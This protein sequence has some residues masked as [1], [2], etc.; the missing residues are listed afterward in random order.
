[1]I[2]TANR[3]YLVPLICLA[4]IL[5]IPVDGVTGDSAAQNSTDEINWPYQLSDL[6]PDPSIVR[7]ILPNG[8]RYI[9]KKNSEPEDRVAAY[10][11]VLAGSMEETDDEQGVAHFLEHLMFNGSTNFPPGTLIDYFQSIGMDF[12][13][14]I[15]AYTGFEKT[16]YHLILPNGKGSELDIGCKVLADYARGAL[17]LDTEIDS[18][19]GV[20]FSEKRSRDSASYRNHVASSEFSFKGTRYPLRRP[21]GKESVLKAAD[22]KLLK[23]YYDSW[24]RLDNMILVLVGDLDLDVAIKAITANFGKLQSEGIVKA[25]PEF[26]ALEHTGVDV[27]YRYDPEIGKTNVSIETYWDVS[28]EPPSV[29]DEK[30]EIVK[31][32][33]NLVVGYRLQQVQETAEQPYAGARYSAGIVARR[34]G[35]G[36]ILGVT[37]SKSWVK[38]LRVLHETIESARLYGFTAKEVTRAKKEIHANLET[39]VQTESSLHS[40]VIAERIVNHFVD[41]D[42]YMSP[43][44]ERALYGPMLD[45][46]TIEDINK[47]FNKIWENTSRLISVTGDTSLDEGG[48]AE[49]KHLYDSLSKINYE[50]KNDEKEIV[51]PYLELPAGAAEILTKQVYPALGVSRYVYGNGLI[52]NLKRTDFEENKIRISANFGRG[53]QDEDVQGMAMIA[54]DVI[55]LSGTKRLNVSDLNSVMAGSSVKLS[56]RIGRQSST[57]MGSALSEDIDLFVQLLHTMLLDSKFDEVAFNKVMRRIQLMYKKLDSDIDGAV[58]RKVQPF[59]G[60]NNPHYGLPSLENLNLLNYSD[61]ESWAEEHFEIHDLEINVVG[62]FDEGHIV[63][64]LQKTFGGLK[65]GPSP[66]RILN[67]K[68]IFPE[69][70]ELVARVP[71]EI[72]KSSVILTW[73]TDDFWNIERTRRLSILASVLEDRIR[74]TVREKLGASYSPSVVSYGSRMHSHH[75]YIQ[76]ELNIESGKEKI[77][78]GEIRKIVRQLVDAGVTEDELSRAKKPVITSV[79]ENIKTNQY[80][81]YSVLSLSDSYPE[82]L[83]WPKTIVSDIKSINVRQ[84]DTLA[85]KYLNDQKV[86]VAIIKA[87]PYE[88]IE[89]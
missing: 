26:G 58:L 60:G 19:R 57:W 44:Q 45:E 15:N 77:L 43:M 21:I 36:S 8:L 83:E 62:D 29:K 69:G 82:Q 48:K 11:A 9:L 23:G 6:E 73:P 13:G 33:G 56:Y 3:Y 61:M 16:V 76:V 2:R 5:L 22:H 68:I 30:E 31:I 84:V 7:G 20:I 39:G 49:I 4:M 54:D 53:E 50:P 87:G 67:E 25:K 86:A 32:I 10:L 72:E 17:L 74:K 78:V 63:S 59:L 37:D 24:Y 35:Y 42:V 66:Q 51:F 41:G 28:P 40:R 88:S 52:V 64:L 65:L 79:L 55:N 75:G 38:T 46:I 12:G 85:G 71:S 70:K 14:D 18:E 81:L 34:I 27:F 47:G 80:W 1:M 89:N